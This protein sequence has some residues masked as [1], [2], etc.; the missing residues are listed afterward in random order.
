MRSLLEKLI[1][2]MDNAGLGPWREWSVIVLVVLVWLGLIG[3]L[4]FLLTHIN[5]RIGSKRLVVTLL[6]IPVRWVHYDNVRNLHTHRI[7]FAEKWHNMLFPRSDRILVIEKRRGLFRR[8]VI[9]PEVRYVFKAELDRAIRAH[10]GLKPGPTAAETTTYERLA[11][12]AEAS[13]AQ[14]PAVSSPPA[15]AGQA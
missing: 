7:R 4:V 2:T 5:Y 1:T 9:T 15:T 13:S 10:L 14:A 3:F 11:A 12:A 6:G 8:L